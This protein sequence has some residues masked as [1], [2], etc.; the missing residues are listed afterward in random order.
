MWRFQ[1][2][3]IIHHKNNYKPIEVFGLS[4]KDNSLNFFIVDEKTESLF[5]VSGKEYV[6]EDAEI[7]GAFHFVDT[8]GGGYLLLHEALAIDDLY[9]DLI[10]REVGAFKTLLSRISL[11]SSL[12]CDSNS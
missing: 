8:G 6:I 12:K 4:I 5:L 11:V 3:M 1:N 10:E 2:K 7:K 9:V